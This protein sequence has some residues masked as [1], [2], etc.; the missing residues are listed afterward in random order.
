M[1]RKPTTCQTLYE[2][3]EFDC[4]CTRN[5]P[6]SAS[7]GIRRHH[8]PQHITSLAERVVQLEG[9]MKFLKLTMKNAN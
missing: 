8:E 9:Q 7:Q 1:P 6:E 4:K 5:G 2:T 3:K